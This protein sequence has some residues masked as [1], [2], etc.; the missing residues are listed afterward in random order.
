MC[1]GINGLKQTEKERRPQIEAFCF[2]TIF[3]NYR[4]EQ[5]NMYDE[6]VKGIK[7]LYKINLGIDDND[8]LLRAQGA[9]YMFMRNNE[10]LKELLILEYKKKKEYLPFILEAQ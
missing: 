3:N 6:F 5:F 10:N 9:M 4:G 7:E 8:K 1:T 2:T